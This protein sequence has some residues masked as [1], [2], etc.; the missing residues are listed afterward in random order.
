MYKSETIAAIST[1]MSNSGIGIVRISGEDAMDIADK[2]FVPLKNN[3]KIKD[4]KSHT[5]HYGNIIYDGEIIDEVLLMIMKAPNT[6]TKEDVVEINC[7]GGIL[8]MKKI[9]ESVLKNGARCAQPGEFTKRAFLNGRIDLAQAEAVIN[10]INAKSDMALE[11]SVNQLKGSMSVKIKKIREKLLNEIAYI[12][13]ALD[14]PEHYNMEDYGVELRPEIIDISD[15]LKKILDTADDGRI[16]TEGIKTVILGKPNVGK[17]SL[18]NCLMGEERA[19]V[20][21]IAGTTRDSLEENVRIRGMNLNIIDTAGIRNT[22]DKVEKIGV[23]KAKNIAQKADLILMI[24]D[25]STKLDN[26]DIKIMDI[27]KDKKALILLNKTDLSAVVDKKDVEKVT[28]KK[29]IE[30]SVKEEKGI[31]DVIMNIENMFYKGNINYNSE[32]YI[33][34][35]RH[36]EAVR[37]AVESLKC[38]IDSIDNGMPEDFLTIDMM[39]AYESLGRITG[40][41]VEDDLIN[42]IFGKFC[43]G[44]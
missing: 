11:M 14:D 24:I 4:M 1:S 21:D 26:E 38:V 9:L 37:D 35:E 41:N 34:N 10:L 12:E 28:D 8:V 23:E 30:I 31:E 25:S 5:I 42:E 20:T 6:Y 13:A 32:V 7:H 15:R 33:T 39:S 43:M 3:K 2:I 44:K 17:S 40:E 19:I 36:K 18:L 16:I 27:I 29:I 22:D